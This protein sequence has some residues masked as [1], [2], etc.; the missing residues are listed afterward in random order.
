MHPLFAATPSMPYIPSPGFL[1]RVVTMPFR[2]LLTVAQYYTV[3][4]PV[5][6]SA[7]FQDSLWKNVQHMALYHLS[8]SFKKHDVATVINK[9]AT[10][11]IDLFRQSLLVKSLT[12]YGVKINSSSY[13]VVQNDENATEKGDLLVYVHGG[14]FMFGIFEAGWAGILALYHAVPADKRKRLSIAAL[15]YSVTAD[16]KMF[17]TQLSELVKLY[18]DLHDQGYREITFIGDLAGANLVLAFLRYTAYLDEAKATF[19]PFTDLWWRFDPVTQPKAA[20][21]VSPWVQPTVYNSK[22]TPYGL[23]V[24][25]DLGAEKTYLGL[26]YVGKNPDPSWKP[27]YAYSEGTYSDLWENVPAL[28]DPKRNLV[29]YGDHELLRAG[30]ERF[31][32]IASNEK[33]DNLTVVME[34][35]AYHDCVFYIES[36]DFV[37]S[38]GPKDTSKIDFSGKFCFNIYAKYL[39]ELIGSSFDS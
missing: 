16:D 10:T 5:Q 22:K 1:G 15:D 36:L 32:D 24:V 30:I 3:G 33:K 26:C 6:H 2:I 34:E 11:I 4:T 38:K 19:S 12:N 31:L 28:N 27:W 9:P 8:L 29:V 35:N 14:G 13:W 20:I 23:S 21:L 39:G 37:S 25:G 18:Y 7:E 17:P